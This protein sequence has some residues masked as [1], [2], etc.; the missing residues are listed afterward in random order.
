[1]AK[2]TRP[3]EL[4]QQ[5]T[6][7]G[8]ILGMLLRARP[9]NIFAEEVWRRVTAIAARNRPMRRLEPAFELLPHNMAVGTD[10]RIVGE[11]RPTLGISKGIDVIPDGNT[12]KRPEQDALNPAN[13]HL[14][15]SPPIT[16]DRVALFSPAR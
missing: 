3:L 2:K 14:V 12:D 5:Q 1:L 7:E 13:L 4:Y 16:H 15:S 8:L 11:I 6:G 10:R 9:K